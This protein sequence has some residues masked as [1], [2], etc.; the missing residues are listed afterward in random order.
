MSSLYEKSWEFLTN[1]TNAVSKLPAD[2][3]KA[4]HACGQV[5]HKAS[6][7]YNHVVSPQL[8]APKSQGLGAAAKID[9]DKENV[10]SKASSPAIH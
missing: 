1:V 7:V 2:V 5:L 9:R 3:I 8:E 6:T 4:I 10:P